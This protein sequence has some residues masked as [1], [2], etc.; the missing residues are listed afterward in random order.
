VN[1]RSKRERAGL[2]GGQLTHL[3]QLGLSLCRRP[4]CRKNF[5]LLQYS[6]GRFLLHVGRVSVF[7]EYAFDQDS[8]VSSATFLHGPIMYVR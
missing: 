5:G 3:W 6:Q 4:V 7:S 8:E 2:V 1:S